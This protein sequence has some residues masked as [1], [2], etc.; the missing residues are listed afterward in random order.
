LK[1]AGVEVI[2]ILNME[3]GKHK[4]RALEQL[5]PRKFFGFDWDYVGRRI[6]PDVP[7]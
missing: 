2:H 7:F 3:L 1:R 4:A 5:L 6:D